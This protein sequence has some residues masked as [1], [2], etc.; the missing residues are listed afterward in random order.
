MRRAGGTCVGAPFLLAATLVLAGPLAHAVAADAIE[1]PLTG[2]RGDPD[3]GRALALARERGNCGVCHAIPSAEERTHGNV[4]PALK[5]VADR[6]SEGQIRARIVDARRLNPAS[7]MPSYFRTE[8]LKRVGAA[9]AGQP[10][11]SAAEIEDVVAFM[12]TL[13]DGTPKR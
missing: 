4:G 2:A 3:K 6:L 8:G 10:V 11:L 9:F 1:T 13:R 12:M 5:G 7:L